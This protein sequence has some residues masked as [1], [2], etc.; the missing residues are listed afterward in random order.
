MGTIAARYWLTD[1]PTGDRPLGS[2]EIV[3]WV[4]AHGDHK[5]C[6]VQHATRAEALAQ[7]YVLDQ[8][9]EHNIHYHLHSGDGLI[10][11]EYVIDGNGGERALEQPL[12][13]HG[14]VVA[15]DAA[16]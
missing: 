14:M 9:I 13:Y 8:E 12:H 10:L 7:W 15:R 1:R 2:D 11:R 4:S 5:D 3:V 16:D 6:A